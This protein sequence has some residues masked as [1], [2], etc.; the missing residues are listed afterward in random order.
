LP[1]SA[2]E[3]AVRPRSRRI[4]ERAQLV[5]SLR[6]PRLGLRGI[7][8]LLSIHD[9]RRQLRHLLLA[10]RAVVDC[11][12]QALER[13]VG[14][15]LALSR[16]RRRLGQHA[17]IALHA[18]PGQCARRTGRL[19]CRLGGRG[20]LVLLLARPRGPQTGGGRAH[21]C[22]GRV[23]RLER[24]RQRPFRV[25]LERADHERL[26]ARRERRTRAG[27]GRGVG[28]VVERASL[29]AR[30][31]LRERALHLLERALGDRLVLH[32]AL[33]GA[34]LVDA[35]REQRDEPERGERGERERDPD[36]PHD[37]NR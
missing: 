30:E 1:R 3:L 34:P 10:H 16:R 7:R 17:L 35:P 36:P 26:E 4:A 21:A 29:L 8:E 25:D 24:R 31:E 6:V 37:E 27:R 19:R 2:R 13:V 12:V 5:L 20:R 33:G 28:V 22:D 18:G 14:A 23:G 11:A 15:D 32:R 9:A